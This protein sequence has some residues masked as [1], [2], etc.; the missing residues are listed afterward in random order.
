MF[1]PL[2][3]ACDHTPAHS[4]T[5]HTEASLLLQHLPVFEEKEMTL[6]TEKTF[7]FPLSAVQ[8]AV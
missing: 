1:S 8:F 3:T 6:D 7:F 4:E 2:S 5:N